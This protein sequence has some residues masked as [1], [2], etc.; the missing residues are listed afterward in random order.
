MTGKEIYSLMKNHFPA[1]HD[2]G[3]SDFEFSIHELA[4]FGVR[5]LA[6]LEKLIIENKEA[7]VE[8]DKNF[9]KDKTEAYEA[10]QGKEF[11]RDRL[12]N[13]YFF[14]YQGLIIVAL[15]IQFPVEF[16]SREMLRNR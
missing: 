9:I 7:I 13:E 8:H 2:F 12:E 4:D 15:K 14:S 10:L 11:V 1:K 5:T 6:Q 16:S 3:G